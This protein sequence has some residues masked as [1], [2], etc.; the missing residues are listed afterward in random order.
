MAERVTIGF[1]EGVADVRF[2]RPDKINALDTAQLEAIADAIATLAAMKG[3]RAVTLSGEGRGFCVGI[4]L[5]SLAGSAELRRL[6]ARIHGDA[7][8]FQQ[9]AWGWRT[10]P[11]PVIAAVHGFAFGAGL[12]IALGADIRIAAPDAELAMMEAR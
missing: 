12:Q 11:V 8:L 9:V 7:N 2:A 5:E 1:D 6:A 10:L 3:L 4:D